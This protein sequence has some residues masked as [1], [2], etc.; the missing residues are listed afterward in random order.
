[1]LGGF[2]NLIRSQAGFTL[3]EL[4]VAIALLGVISVTVASRWF[5]V[6]AFHSNTLRAQLL[7]EARLAQR[8]ALANSQL[9]VSLVISQVGEQW[10][11][12]IYTDDGSGRTLF[13]ETSSDTGGVVIEVTAGAS[14]NLAAGIDFDLTYDGLGNLTDLS[15]GGVSLSPASGIQLDLTGA[16]MCFSPLGYAHEGNCV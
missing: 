7:A 8:T 10:H 5:S 16:R 3:V 15:V 14:Q 13:R 4:V 6:D 11:Y 2:R 12:Q 9:L 1:M